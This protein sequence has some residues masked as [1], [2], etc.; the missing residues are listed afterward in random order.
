MISAQLFQ[1]LQKIPCALL[2]V[3]YGLVEGIRWFFT[4]FVPTVVVSLNGLTV[5]YNKKECLY[6]EL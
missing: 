5:F 4:S 3:L 6:E 2:Y 1:Q